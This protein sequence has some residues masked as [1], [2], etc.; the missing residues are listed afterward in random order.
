MKTSEK[1]ESLWILTVSPAIWSAHFL[2]SYITAAIWCAKYAGP[3]GSLR[4]VRWAI[5]IYTI[6]ALAG[7]ALTALLGYRKHSFKGASLPH[8]FDTREDRHRFI[9][10]A[11]ILLSGLSA[12]ATVYVALA[13]VFIGDC[14]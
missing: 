4:E 11:T 6:L 7:I 9:G 14:H 5:A 2:L 13:A 10:F 3:G 12:A 8:D 1:E